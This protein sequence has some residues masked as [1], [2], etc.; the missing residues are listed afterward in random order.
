MGRHCYYAG[1]VSLKQ[2]WAFWWPVG[3]SLALTP[4]CLLIGIMSGAGGH[5]NYLLAKLLFPWTMLST[6]L[7]RFITPPFVAVAV[8]QYPAYGVALGLANRNGGLRGAAKKLLAIHASLA[9]ACL[10][11]PNPNF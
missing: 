5:G 3:V 9:A 7:L 10:I 11:V 2:R 6:V 4:L 8:L 1:L